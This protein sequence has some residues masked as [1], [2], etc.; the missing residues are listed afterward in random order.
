MVGRR[1]GGR[2]KGQWWGE[3]GGGSR[4]G[5]SWNSSGDGDIRIGSISEHRMG[6]GT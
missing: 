1:G 5:E 4:N 6:A 3:G 2:E